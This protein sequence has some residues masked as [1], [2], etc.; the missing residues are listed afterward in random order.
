[1]SIW[2]FLY[3]PEGSDYFLR[4]DLG[5]PSNSLMTSPGRQQQWQETLG[6]AVKAP[7]SSAVPV[8]LPYTI[9]GAKIS[10]SGIPRNTTK[11]DRIRA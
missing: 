10:F 5:H 11:N 1:M 3:W 6:F 2:T 7:A 9:L 8:S 4:G